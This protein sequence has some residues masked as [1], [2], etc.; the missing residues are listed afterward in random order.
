MDSRVTIGWIVDMLVDQL[1]V[2][3][4]SAGQE[5]HCILGCKITMLDVRITVHWIVKSLYTVQENHYILSYK[6]IKLDIVVT[7]QWTIR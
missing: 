7:V 4:L 2:E 6:I 1:I 5:N 3:S